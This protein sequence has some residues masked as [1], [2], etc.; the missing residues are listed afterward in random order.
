LL[1]HNHTLVREVRFPNQT[2]V[3]LAKQKKHYKIKAGHLKK[4]L[5]VA[6]E[7]SS[8]L[9]ENYEASLQDAVKLRVLVESLRAQKDQA[10]AQTEA[11]RM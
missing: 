1:E 8:L 10:D 7:E 4:T 6:D 9:H 5:A 2:C 11:C 3:E